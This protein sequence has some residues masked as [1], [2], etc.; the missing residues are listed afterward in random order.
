MHRASQDIKDAH[1]QTLKKEK[2]NPAELINEAAGTTST[3]GHTRTLKMVLQE[4]RLQ[5][6]NS[7]QTPSSLDHRSKVFT[8]KKARQYSRQCHQQESQ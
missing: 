7:A 2:R 8:L 5:Q 4:R 3:K 6:G 1:S